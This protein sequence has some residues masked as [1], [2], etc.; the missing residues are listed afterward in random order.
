MRTPESAFATRE[1]LAACEALL[2]T[3]SR[4][5]FSASRVLPPSVRAPAIA[6]YAFCRV[7]DDVVDIE[8]GIDALPRLH[9]R[10]DAIY[11][12]QPQPAAPDRALAGLA[13]HFALPRALLDALLEGFEWD[14]RGQRYHDLPALEAYAARVAG[15]VGAM[16][17]VLM[18]ARRADV[19]AR[20][21]DLGV[22]MQLTNIARDVGEDARAGRLYLP[23][24]WLAQ[25]G[26]DA[27]GW[28]ARPVFT[29][30][31]GGV[32]QRL[33]D[34]ADM[35]YRRATTGIGALPPG[36]RPG[37]QAARHLY[38]EIGRE[39]E[40]RGLD[41]VSARAVV[42]KR[43]KSRLLARA[44]AATLLPSR[45]DPAPPLDATRFLVEA[46]VHTPAPFVIGRPSLEERVRWL[47]ELFERLERRTGG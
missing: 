31:L 4:T 36:C 2:R 21:C 34:H 15:S 43:R 33:L 19:V 13:T 44:L 16:M 45:V 18:G 32:V 9:A 11:A 20:A 3:G 39:V 28:L 24:T 46:V 8:G 42:S 47:V 5:F 27:D 25:A 12:G 26:I 30:A 22:A 37:M 38:A 40:R 29:P 23:V 6:L 14:A 1:D 35:L 41:S 7:A 10:L 17:A